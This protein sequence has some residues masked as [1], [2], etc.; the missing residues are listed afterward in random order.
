M[1]S[2]ITKI[3]QLEKEPHSQFKTHSPDL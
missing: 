3:I 1:S 2:N